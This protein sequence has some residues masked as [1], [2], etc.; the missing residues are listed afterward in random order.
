MRFTRLWLIAS[1]L[2]AALSL[3]TPVFATLPGTTLTLV[4]SANPTIAKQELTLTATVSPSTAT[5][6]VTFKDGS[7]TLGTAPLVSGVATFTT[8]KLTVGNHT[9][10][11]SYGGDTS[12]AAS[13]ATM[14][15]NPQVVIKASPT[16]TVTSSANPAVTGQSVTFQALISPATA[17]G[18]ITFKNGATTLGTGTLTSGVAT[19]K[20]SSLAVG[21]S[22]TINVS[23]PGDANDNSATGSLDGNPQVVNKGETNVLLTGSPNPSVLGQAVKFTAKVTAASPALG[24]PSGTVTFVN[25]DTGVPLGSGTLSGGVASYTTTASAFAAGTYNIAANYPGDTKFNGNSSAIQQNVTLDHTTVTVTSSL[26]PAVTGQ[27]VK[28]TIAVKAVSPATGTPTGTVTL[29]DNG[30]PI[31]DPVSLTSGTASVSTNALAVGTHTM[32]ASYSGDGTKFDV[33]TGHMSTLQTIKQGSSTMT[34]KSS[35]NPSFAGQSVMFTAK[36]TAVS[37]ATGTPT[38]NVTFLD[39]ANPIGSGIVDGGVATFTT[40]SLAAGSHTITASYGG[41]SNFMV[42]TGTAMTGNPQVVKSVATL[43]LTTTSLPNATVG[44]AYNQALAVTGGLQP[45]T[46]AITSGSLP[47]GLSLDSNSGKITGTPTSEGDS[48]FTA[49]VTDSVGSTSSQGLGINSVIVPLQIT[50]TSLPAAMVGQA[51]SP[52]L[53]T[54]GG[55]GAPVTWSVSSGSL[56]AWATLNQPNGANPASITGTPALTDVGSTQFTLTASD[57]T[58]SPTQQLTIH[59]TNGVNNAELNGHYA[60]RAAGFNEA[61]GAF[62]TVT[63]AFIANGDGSISGGEEDML[64]FDSTN[65]AL[66]ISATGNGTGSGYGIGADHRGSLTIVTSQGTQT[67]V[68]ALGA[69]TNGVSASGRLTSTDNGL[70]VSGE[71]MQQISNPASANFSGHHAFAASGTDGSLNRF[72]VAGENSLTGSA[73]SSGSGSGLLDVNDGGN[74][75]NGA[76]SASPQSF[77]ESFTAPDANGRSEVTLTVNGNAVHMAQYAVTAGEAFVIGTDPV[78]AGSNNQSLYSG[79]GLTRTTT[80]FSNSSLSGKSVIYFEGAQ[81]PNSCGQQ[82]CGTDT[83]V[84]LLNTS[85]G[86]FSITLQ[87][88]HDGDVSTQNI[89][90]G[91][92]SVASSGRVTLTNAGDHPPLFYLVGPNQAVGVGQGGSAETGFMEPQTATTMSG[93]YIF[94]TLPFS[95]LYSSVESGVATFSA[96]SVSGSSDHVESNPPDTNVYTNQPI[97]NTYTIDN[98]G[99]VTLGDVNKTDMIGYV[100]SSS[101]TIMIHIGASTATPSVGT[102]DSRIT[103][104]QK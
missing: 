58:N 91:G 37:P 23:Y 96:G 55:V 52:Q 14:T 93:N 11:A 95:D 41:D 103:I 20:T 99:L 10:S 63:G 104:V 45:Y 32:S 51:Y 21:G 38:G 84:G 42:K 39:G 28:F 61:T 90:G 24:T 66:A 17:T 40:T 70:L 3:G 65:T 26:N 19:Y 30:N 64:T 78:A 94:G 75:N 46:F 5:G 25:T 9:I 81:Q 7:T 2:S 15:G 13:T 34:L 82:D 56:P 31:S 29:M 50:T 1:V 89:S 35:L 76:G 59:V 12:D 47:D 57:G 101:K 53:L 98:T 27:T 4:S 87:Q 74:V 86:T 92:Y 71:L 60:F 68:V 18:S 100:V 69:I 8:V 54:S 62:Y 49:Q 80:S 36:V 67:F 43:T 6:T 83:T 16:I 48:P 22:Y 88:D 97:S 85:S 77:T 72:A 44:T 79:I 102:P 33:S 73:G